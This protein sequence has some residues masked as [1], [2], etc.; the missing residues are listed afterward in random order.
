MRDDLTQPHAVPHL[1]EYRWPVAAH[2]FGVAGHHVQIGTDGRRQ[3]SLVDHEQVTLRD[4][5]PALARHLIAAS[6]VDHVNRKIG[7]FPAEIRGQVVAA[8]FD[9]QQFGLELFVQVF[10]RD[11][12]GRDVFTDGR[13]RA[14]AGFGRR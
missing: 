10:E 8:A 5:R 7:Q 14:A 6:N 2:A 3:I 11:Q 13:V 12:V 1:S 9:E 4:A